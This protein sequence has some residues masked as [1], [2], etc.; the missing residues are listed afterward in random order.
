MSYAGPAPELKL[1]VKFIKP[2][3][4]GFNGVPMS[5][6]KPGHASGRDA[7]FWS[8]KMNEYL[9]DS[10]LHQQ[11]IGN[12]GEARF[13]SAAY[14]SI[15]TG[16]GERFGV[17]IDRNNIKNRLKHIKEAF[18]E[19]RNILGEDTRIKWC[20]ES[21]RFNADPNVWR[22]LIQVLVLSVSQE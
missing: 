14:D 12:R 4:W 1:P 16:V 11:S 5:Y 19:C 15:I 9:I 21:R 18:Y 22:E 2:R 8:D 13:F 3:I 20:P 7:V 17:A 6:I 10:L